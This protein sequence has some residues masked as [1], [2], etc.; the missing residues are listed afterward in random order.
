MIKKTLLSIFIFG[1]FISQVFAGGSFCLDI[2]LEPILNQ[3][4]LIKN[5][6]LETFDIAEKGIFIKGSAGCSSTG[7]LLK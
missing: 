1:A 4:P 7:Y 5:L 6:V 3:Q 2:E